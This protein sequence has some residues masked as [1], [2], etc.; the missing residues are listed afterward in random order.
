M[1][2]YLS[3]IKYKSNA[4]KQ[5]GLSLTL[6]TIALLNAKLSPGNSAKITKVK[7]KTLKTETVNKKQHI[8]LAKR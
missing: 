8:I 6:E 2:A 1:V 4:P 5:R 3:R 7:A